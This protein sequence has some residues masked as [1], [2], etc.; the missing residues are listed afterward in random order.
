MNLI[1]LEMYGIN[2]TEKKISHDMKIPNELLL[3]DENDY[4][5]IRIS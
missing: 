3:Y 1:A 5:I 4:H 2:Q